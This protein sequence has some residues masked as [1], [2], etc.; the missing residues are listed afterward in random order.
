[1]RLDL[2]VCVVLSVLL[3]VFL[4]ECGIKIYM[5]IMFAFSGKH[6]AEMSLS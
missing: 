6:L 1:L 5:Y 4:T 3:S 2:D